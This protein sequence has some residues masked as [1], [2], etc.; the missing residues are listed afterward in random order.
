MLRG[1]NLED[2]LFGSIRFCSYYSRK[3]L[4][5]ERPF[6]EKA[7]LEVT[8]L[9]GSTTIRLQTFGLRHLVY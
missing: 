8:V 6:L 3:W 2:G 4:F 5:T 7:R 1:M 9:K